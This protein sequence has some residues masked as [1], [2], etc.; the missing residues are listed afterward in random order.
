[1]VLTL[2]QVIFDSGHSGTHSGTLLDLPHYK[3]NEVYVPWLSKEKRQIKTPRG[4]IGIP[5]F[6]YSFC[7]QYHTD[8]FF[9]LVRKNARIRSPQRRNGTTRIP[10]PQVPAPLHPTRIRPETQN[11]RRELRLFL[12]LK[13]RFM[14][15]VPTPGVGMSADAE[16][17]SGKGLFHSLVERHS[18]LSCANSDGLCPYHSDKLFF[19]PNVVGIIAMLH[20]V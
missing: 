19:H 9:I 7:F 13:Q 12:N 15:S 10:P 4:E 3:C 5:C 14:P 6:H 8:Q 16:P 1:V 20:H 18:S 17:W 2:Y 11:R